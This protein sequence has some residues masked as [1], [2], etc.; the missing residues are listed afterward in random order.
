MTPTH[1]VGPE[2]IAILGEALAAL[3]LPSKEASSTRTP[4][5]TSQSEVHRF[6]PFTAPF[7]A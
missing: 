5:R 3:G 4:R 6:G 7:D 1:S 2:A